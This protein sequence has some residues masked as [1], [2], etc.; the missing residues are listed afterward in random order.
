[1]LNTNHT[2]PKNVFSSFEHKMIPTGQ[3]NK[4]SKKRNIHISINRGPTPS[5]QIN[6]MTNIATCYKETSEKIK[7]K[8]DQG[9]KKVAKNVIEKN[10]KQ[11][12]DTG[13]INALHSMRNLDEGKETN[14]NRLL[15]RD[16]S[17]PNRNLTNYNT[18]N[19]SGSLL[20][21][22]TN[23]NNSSINSSYF[24]KNTITTSQL[25]QLNDSNSTSKIHITFTHRNYNDSV[26]LTNIAN[27]SLYDYRVAGN[28]ANTASNPTSNYNSNPNTQVNNPYNNATN[29][30]NINTSTSGNNIKLSSSGNFS[31]INVNTNSSVSM[32]SNSLLKKNK[33]SNALSTGNKS[34][35]SNNV[36]LVNNINQN[37]GQSN[38]IGISSKFS[39]NTKKLQFLN[40][41]NKSASNITN[42]G[43][44]N[45]S[46]NI[47]NNISNNN[48]INDNRDKEKLI[49]S[50][51]EKIPG[52][53]SN[54]ISL[55]TKNSYTR[56][57]SLNMSSNGNANKLSS[58]KGT[59]LS[60]HSNANTY[61]TNLIR[62]SQNYSSAGVNITTNN[63][64]T[65]NNTNTDLGQYTQPAIELSSSLKP[66]DI[67]EVRNYVKMNKIRS[68]S[69]VHNSSHIKN[70]VANVGVIG[71]G[72][73]AYKSRHT[74]RN[75]SVGVI[76]N[77]NNNTPITGISL[78]KKERNFSRD[79][80][81]GVKSMDHI[82]ASELFN[83]NMKRN[84]DN[85]TGNEEI[86]N[87]TNN[88]SNAG[89]NS[90]LKN[91]SSVGYKAAVDNFKKYIKNNKSLSLIGIKEK[92]KELLKNK[93]IPASLM[94]KSFK[95]STDITSKN[96]EKPSNIDNE[97][98]NRNNKYEFIKKKEGDT[99]DTK[100]FNKENIDKV[101]KNIIYNEDKNRIKELDDNLEDFVKSSR[102]E[103][104]YENINKQASG[105][106]EGNIGYVNLS[107][108]NAIP[109][110]IPKIKN[111]QI[112]K[113]TTNS[114]LGKTN[115]NTSTNTGTSTNPSNN[116]QYNSNSTSSAKVNPYNGN[117]ITINPQPDPINSSVNNNRPNT[118]KN[119]MILPFSKNSKDLQ[120]Q[121]L[122]F[123]IQ[124]NCK[125]GTGNTNNTSD[126]NNN[127]S[128]NL[129]K[130]HHPIS[131]RGP[132]QAS[133]SLNA[134]NNKI[135][136][137][138]C[139]SINSN[140]NL[141]KEN[142]ITCK[143]SSI[144]QEEEPE[145][146]K[147]HPPINNPETQNDEDDDF[148]L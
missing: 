49:I 70:L 36:L 77:N 12:K 57:N 123:I 136:S 32:S 125:N 90:S 17:I 127:T 5:F 27:N 4:P 119:K 18:T 141:L 98:D 148:D 88:P 64:Y 33:S 80:L 42:T 117:I 93:N 116:Q 82:T 52:N 147:K 142:L 121:N 25:S 112:N 83:L 79:R 22:K 26:N 118:T 45:N 106:N 46:N 31:N 53:I 38:S 131:M 94:I 50:T 74:K 110:N 41:R 103:I 99:Q 58:N 67:E 102:E 20:I 24:P 115:T 128:T 34:I 69:L 85:I 2:S 28:K 107:K 91:T 96:I 66:S 124:D 122:K 51:N 81:L 1:M 114:G 120:M 59:Y 137:M 138:D 43:G 87:N 143:S 60:T 63:N 9:A 37:Q 73:N 89:L 40:V 54:P 65:S 7:G 111:I 47:S 139:S 95:L 108:S 145:T 56:K 101:V 23:N 130:Q 39:N 109:G 104:K 13:Y 97:V 15:P 48:Y 11:D 35:H 8:N 55:S 92:Y 61:I 126:I 144:I 62:P 75:S 86:G 133:R 105:V 29:N 100:S 129:I 76:N 84:K 134:K 68:G 3:E 44:A 30:P 135:L 72:I 140:V 19:V 146:I 10:K 21:N 14:M 71:S 113:N 132:P 16:L 6:K 78:I